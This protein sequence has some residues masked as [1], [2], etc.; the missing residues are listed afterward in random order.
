MS[1]ILMILGD[2][3]GSVEDSINDATGGGGVSSVEDVIAPIVITVIF[4]VGIIAAIM[5]IVGGVNYAMSQGDSGKVKKAK[6]TIMYGI[7]GLVVA[8][9]AFAIVSF[10]LDAIMR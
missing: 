10:A 1:K 8:I 9:L 7:I 5:I 3:S 2:V 4:L 6:D